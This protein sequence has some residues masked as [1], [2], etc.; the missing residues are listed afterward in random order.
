MVIASG[1]SIRDR[2]RSLQSA[3][4]LFACLTLSGCADSPVAPDPRIPPTTGAPDRLM[5]IDWN[6]GVSATTCRAEATWGYLYSTSRDVTTE[7]VWESSA[8]QVAAVAGPG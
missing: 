7:S 4:V 1:P 6:F 2:L 5:V 3:I 8:P